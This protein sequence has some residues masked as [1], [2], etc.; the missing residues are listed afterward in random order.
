VL[1]FANCYLLEANPCAGQAAALSCS[2]RTGGTLALLRVS[3]NSASAARL[4]DRMA[5]AA[6]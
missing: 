1:F 3:S 6:E 5:P 2:S 4:P